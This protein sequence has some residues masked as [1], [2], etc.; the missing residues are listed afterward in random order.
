M[1]GQPE[2]GQRPGRML[3]HPRVMVAETAA[4]PVILEGPLAESRGGEAPD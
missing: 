3:I 4:V 1:P 2:E